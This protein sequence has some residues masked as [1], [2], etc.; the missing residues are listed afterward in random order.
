MQYMAASGNPRYGLSAFIMHHQEVAAN[1]MVFAKIA[2]YI[3][4]CINRGD[5]EVVLERFT[6]ELKEDVI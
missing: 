1:T 6:Q 5:E 2:W 4:D 3:E